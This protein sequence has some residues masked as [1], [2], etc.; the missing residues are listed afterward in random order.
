[1]GKIVPFRKRRKWT[2]CRDYPTSR[3]DRNKPS[4]EGRWRYAREWTAAAIIGIAAGTAWAWA[5][6]SFPP[7]IPKFGNCYAG[8]G[9]NCVV[10]GDTFYMDSVKI[11]IAGIDAP[12]T[13]PPRCAREEELGFAAAK[14]L[15][16]LLNSGP[17]TL[18]II[19][20]DEDVYGRKLRNV[21]VDG[22]D[23]G[24]ALVREGLAHWYANGK[25]PW[26]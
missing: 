17:V 10:D 11:R 16:V 6:P 8:G 19:D 24:G 26:C 22:A 13:H 18:S 5:D 20:R 25:Q 21:Q 4:A 1:M 2:S 7:K 12:E 3:Q 14:R 23:V 15:R 9:K